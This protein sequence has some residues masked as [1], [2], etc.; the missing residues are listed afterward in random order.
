MNGIEI[1]KHT[2][3]SYVRNRKGTPKGILVAVKH[4]NGFGIG[5]S[6]C[7]KNDRF[8]KEMGLRIAIGR[9]NADGISLEALPHA[10]RKAFPEFTKRCLRYYKH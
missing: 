2:I 1:P 9:S 4:G 3:I 6:F 5:Y 7:N 10:I 8:C